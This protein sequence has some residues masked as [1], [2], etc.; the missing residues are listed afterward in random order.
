MKENKMLI[1]KAIAFITLLTSL[2]IIWVNMILKQHER[3]FKQEPLND[4]QIDAMMMEWNGYENEPAEVGEIVSQ[5]IF[6]DSVDNR[7][8]T[9]KGRLIT[10][11]L[12]E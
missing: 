12:N 7:L 5:D 10:N 3:T 4:S 11:N 2:V 6:I 1:F 8:Y 9:S